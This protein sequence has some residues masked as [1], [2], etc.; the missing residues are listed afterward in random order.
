MDSNERM[1]DLMAAHIMRRSVENWES[2]FPED[3]VGHM[4]EAQARELA[5]SC[6]SYWL[7]TAILTGLDRDPVETLADAEALVDI[8]KEVCD[9]VLA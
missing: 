8:M 5:S 7:K 3:P 2:F 6:T 4:G 9:E 1:I